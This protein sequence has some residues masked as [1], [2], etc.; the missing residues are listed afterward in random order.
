MKQW[1]TF[2]DLA[3]WASDCYHHD[4][5]DSWSAIR[6]MRE[7]GLPSDVQAKMLGGNARRMYNIDT[8]MF[9]TE[10]P[11][12]ILRPAWFPGGPELDA[13]AAEQAHPRRQ[14]AAT[15]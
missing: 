13:W 9:V 7:L 12:P 4:A 11:P 6:A 14:T 15:S 8:A 10:E 3:I 2:G 1:D 5:A